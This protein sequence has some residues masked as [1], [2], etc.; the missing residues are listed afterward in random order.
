MIR[1][2]ISSLALAAAVTAQGPLSTT[3]ANN[4]GGI[5]GGAVY[6][7]LE[8][9]DPNG[10]SI[11]SL[12]LNFSNAAGAAGTVEVYIKDASWAPHTDAWIGPVST[13]TVGPTLATGNPTPVTL[14]APIE[15]GPGC[16]FGFAV[17]ADATLS[18]A[19]TT[20][21]FLP[22][23]YSTP[24]LALTVGGASNT[25]FTGISWSPRLA[26]VN[27]H[28]TSG[29]TCP[30]PASATQVGTG[31]LAQFASFYEALPAGL[32]DLDGQKLSAT[33][34]FFGGF[35]VT[36]APGAGFTPPVGSV[37][38]PLGDD[39]AFDTA[40][41][42]GTLGLFVGSNCWVAEGAGNAATFAPNVPEFLANPSRGVYSWTDLQPDAIGSGLVYYHE[43]AG[44]ATVTY[45]GVFGW[46]TQDR[47]FVQI[48]L[49]T[50]SGAWSI[51][52]AGVA[53]TNP[54]AMLV[55]ASPAGVS[56]DPGAT[57][58]SAGALS[59]AVTDIP[60]LE[61]VATGRPVQGAANSLFEVTTTNIPPSAVAHVRLIGLTPTGVPLDGFG[62]L[63]CFQYLAVLDSETNIFFP[64]STPTFTWGIPLPAVATNS[65]V[66]QEFYLQ[67]WV[68]GV[69]AN[70]FLNGM[71]AVTSNALRCKIGTL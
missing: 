12:D 63:G 39:E 29:G 65:L 47:N 8:C 14:S 59:L 62:L 13:G 49:D 67:S 32:F 19:Y 21:T 42:G 7:D 34:D 10:I 68:F 45:D 33:P 41:V 28:Y 16:K 56:A 69:S 18:H 43:S 48:V 37:A 46:G 31:C 24:E 3:F 9:L 54:E 27:V 4:N 5:P 53:A 40:A 36:L 50:T 6:F 55:G 20:A 25:P 17:V 51:E 26:N 2:L 44:V 15:L 1:T 30:A 66:G 22:T 35:D 11:Q 70:N 60:P 23:V 64:T 71:G 38:M 52:W 61:L 57:D 58:I